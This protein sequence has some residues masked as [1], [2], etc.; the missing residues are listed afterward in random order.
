MVE[1][2]QRSQNLVHRFLKRT[3]IHNKHHTMD[4][5][6]FGS[7]GKSS[8]PKLVEITDLFPLPSVNL[9]YYQN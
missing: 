8:K 4:L 5:Q 6:A 3:L 7:E 2:Q 9:A 1:Q